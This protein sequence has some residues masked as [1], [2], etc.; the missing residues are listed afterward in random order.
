[1][2]DQKTYG[3]KQVA[4]RIGTDAKQLRKFFRDPNSGYD[5][6]GQ[7]GRYDFPEEEITKI[8]AAFDAWSSTKTTRNRSPQ[9]KPATP[10]IPGQRTASPTPRRQ[11]VDPKL[12][13][14]GNG[15]DDDDFR[16]RMLGIGERAR[17][18]GLVAGK[19]GK[20]IPKPREEEAAKSHPY[21]PKES[22][23]G[24]MEALD[25][26]QDLDDE[27]DGS[28]NGELQPLVDYLERSLD[29][30]PDEPLDEFDIEDL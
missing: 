10:S 22:I 28:P 19:N 3:A 26:V 8:K 9:S 20:L 2:A 16:T 6:V 30:G 4:S 15:L 27:V 25:D 23:P 24:L 18:H 1:M 7:G 12:G 14:H 17:R 11:R 13:L 29:D 5:G 21:P